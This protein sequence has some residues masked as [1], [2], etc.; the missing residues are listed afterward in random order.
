[1][2]N[3]GGSGTAELVGGNATD[4]RLE[5][6]RLANAFGCHIQRSYVIPL[7]FAVAIPV[8]G[9]CHLIV[10]FY[11][12]GGGGPNSI[13]RGTPSH[14]RLNP[15]FRFNE[16]S[17]SVASRSRPDICL[18]SSRHASPMPSTPVSR[19]TSRILPRL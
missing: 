14:P 13:L 7:S 16:A 1:M 9:T 19:R 12:A 18:W 17:S 5:P 10:S 11:G 4:I 15:I 6:K 2:G 8:N 3:G